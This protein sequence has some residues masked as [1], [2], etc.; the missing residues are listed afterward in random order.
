M[1][2]KVLRRTLLLI[3][4]GEA[5]EIRNTG[6]RPLRML[7]FYIPP[8]YRANGDPLPRGRS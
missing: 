5:H 2:Q 7:N 4:R 1:N 3:E 6:R 8:A